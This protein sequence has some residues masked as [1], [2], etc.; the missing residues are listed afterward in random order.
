M[1]TVLVLFLQ[2]RENWLLQIILAEIDINIA[3]RNYGMSS[4][5]PPE[6]SLME[7]EPWIA[8]WAA[9]SEYQ[10]NLANF[11]LAAFSGWPFFSPG[12]ESAPEDD[13]A[14][15]PPQGKGQPARPMCIWRSKMS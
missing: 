2:R 1:P 15:A 6:T 4:Q 8:P 13:S 3:T 9:L 12:V 5:T 11:W 7:I 10:S 14:D